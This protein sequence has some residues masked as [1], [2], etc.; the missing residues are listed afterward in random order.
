[1]SYLAQTSELAHKTPSMAAMVSTNTIELPK[2]IKNLRTWMPESKEYTDFKDF[3]IV[4]GI[5]YKYHVGRNI[6][7]IKNF[8]PNTR[9]IAFLS[10]FT[11]GGLTI[12]AL[13]RKKMTK[14]KDL[15]LQLIDGRRYTLF[16]VC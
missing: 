7:L 1:M 12:Q 15:N 9:N 5:F 10:D 8:Y 13:V 2:G 14:F 16:G 6:E 3:N 4:G 11:L